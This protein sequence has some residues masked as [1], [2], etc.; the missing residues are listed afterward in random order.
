MDYEE[1][2]EG[3]QQKKLKKRLM[4]QYQRAQMEQQRKEIMQKLLEPAA[5]DRLMNIRLSNP[6]LYVQL[7]NLVISL[8]QSE[9]LS[10]KLTEAQLIAILQKVT[11]KP[12]TKIEYK[13]K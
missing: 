13:H 6:E 5:Y 10:G 3:Q 12:D 8:A 2:S 7:V 11:Y 1:E 9:R 4:E